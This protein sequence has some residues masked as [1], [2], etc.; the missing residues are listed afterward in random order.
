MLR[1][2]LMSRFD[3]RVH[4]ETRD[5]DGF[6]LIV[7]KGG[8]KFKQTSL[9]EEPIGVGPTPT[10]PIPGPA[11][12][13][14]LMVKGRYGM[15]Q[16]AQGLLPGFLENR[17]VIDKTDLPGVYDITFVIDMAT[18]IDGERGGGGRPQ[19]PQPATPV[20]NALEEQLGLRLERAKVPVEFL[21][22]DHI[23]KATES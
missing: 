22:I 21:F 9:N 5:V 17:P 12:I 13:T 4:R 23:E 19:R 2:L 7:A 6:H 3:L 8:I 11:S 18:P 16:F 15:K 20:T 1:A 10:S 14:Q